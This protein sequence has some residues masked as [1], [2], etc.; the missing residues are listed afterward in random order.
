[1]TDR[2]TGRST[3]CS[4]GRRRSRARRAGGASCRS[5]LRRPPSTASSARTLRLRS[6]DRILHRRRYS[7]G[8][9]WNQILHASFD[10]R[11][12]TP[13][14]FSAPTQSCPLVCFRILFFPFPLFH[15]PR[16]L[17]PRCRSAIFW[18]GSSLRL[19]RYFGSSV[20]QSRPFPKFLFFQFSFFPA[21]SFV[22]QHKTCS[23]GLFG[24]RSQT[25][26]RENA[27]R[28]RKPMR[29]LTST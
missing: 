11:S 2:P 21:D 17:A 12:F 27:S 4:A 18:F 29:L 10:F 8:P 3:L 14:E 22:V 20:A 19:V 9:I 5:G 6:W 1:M 25:R 28:V 24:F 16:S 23:L 13:G 15:A 26:E 7:S